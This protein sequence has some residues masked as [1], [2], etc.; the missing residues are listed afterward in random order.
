MWIPLLTAAKLSH[1]RI[2]DLRHTCSTLLYAAGADPKSVQAQLGHQSLTM[3][4]DVYTHHRRRVVDVL[5]GLGAAPKC[6]QNAPAAENS[7]EAAAGVGG[8]R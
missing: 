1:H 7:P 8:L 5:D 3:T 4:L 2:H 6:A